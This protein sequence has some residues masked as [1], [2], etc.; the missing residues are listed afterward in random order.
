MIVAETLERVPE[1]YRD[2]VELRM[3]D[4]QVKEI[5]SILKR[6]K[7]SVERILQ[8]SRRELSILLD[9]DT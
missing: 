8:E 1:D 4:H 7:R 3:Q 5:A 6:S 9:S 2:V